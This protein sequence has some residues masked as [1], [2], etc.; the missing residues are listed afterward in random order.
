VSALRALD[1]PSGKIWAPK[2]LD[3]AAGRNK[4]DGYVGIDLESGSDIVWDLFQ[5]PWP[6]KTGSV[7]EVNVSHFVEHIPHYRPE[8]GARDGWFL[9]WEEVHRITK[10]GALVHIVHP[11][12]MSARAFWDPTHVR[13]IHEMCWYYT[14]RTWREANGLG[15]YTDADFEVVVIS[16][17]GIADDIVARNAEHQAYARAHYWNVIPDLSVEL[18]RR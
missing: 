14:D 12:V 1:A 18:K 17:T 3:I 4:R 11:Y 2:R 5:F 7:V 10:K 13:F 6:I 16:G 15:H 8:W 9:F